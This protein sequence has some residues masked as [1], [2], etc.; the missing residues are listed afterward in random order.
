MNGSLVKIVD[1]NSVMVS[2]VKNGEDGGFII[3]VA[4]YAGKGGRLPLH[5]PT[6]YVLPHPQP[7]LT[8]PNVIF[9]GNATSTERPYPSKSIP[10]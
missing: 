3:R 1:N 5:S 7:S 2:G 4:D 9:S 6:S 10:S 8:S